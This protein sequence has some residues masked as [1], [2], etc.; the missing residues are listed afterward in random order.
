ME[1]VPPRSDHKY[2]TEVE[3]CAAFAAVAR[4][5]GFMVYPE[6]EGWDL[7][8]VDASGYQVGVQ[9]KLQA[10]WLVLW[11]ALQVGSSG[12]PDTRALL[13]PNPPHKFSHLAQHMGVR[14]FSGATIRI[15]PNQCPTRKLADWV[16]SP[17]RMDLGATAGPRIR[18]PSI[19]ASSV[20]AGAP[21]PRSLTRWREAVLLICGALEARGRVSGQQVKQLGLRV[22]ALT[23]R[24][25]LVRVGWTPGRRHGGIYQHGGQPLP[26]VGWS[27]E[28][29]AIWM[30]RGHELEPIEEEDVVAAA[31]PS[32]QGRLGLEIDVAGAAG[33]DDQ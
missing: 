24:G 6:V 25:W 17:K 3:L 7:V 12:N 9:A 15:G 28:K 4:D 5:L 32:S 21:S 33:Q 18:L 2:V 29:H 8:L 14:V 31:P 26:D 1:V 27:D 10:S 19:V 20:V 23:A 11:Q 16:W 30:A 22:S 13:V